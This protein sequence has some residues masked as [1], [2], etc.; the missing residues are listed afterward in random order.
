VRQRNERCVCQHA[1]RAETAHPTS[2]RVWYGR[3]GRRAVVRLGVAWRS[4]ATRR[5]GLGCLRWRAR[6]LACVRVGLCTRSARKAASHPGGRAHMGWTG[7]A[8]GFDLSGVCVR[9]C[10]DVCGVATAATRNRWRVHGDDTETRARQADLGEAVFR[11]EVAEKVRTWGRWLDEHTCAGALGFAATARRSVGHSHRQVKQGLSPSVACVRVRAERRRRGH[12]GD[13]KLMACTRQGNKERGTARDSPTALVRHIRRRTNSRARE[14][15][16]TGSTRK[17]RASARWWCVR[18]KRRQHNRGDGTTPTTW[19]QQWDKDRWTVSGGVCTTRVCAHTTPGQRKARP[20]LDGACS[21]V[22]VPAANRS[23]VTH[24]EQRNDTT[25]RQGSA[26]GD[27]GSGTCKATGSARWPA[28][29]R[30]RVCAAARCGIAVQGHTASSQGS[31]QPQLEGQVHITEKRVVRLTYALDTTTRWWNEQRGM[32]W[33][34]G[35]SAA[36]SM[37]S[38]ATSS[39][40]SSPGSLVFQRGGEEGAVE[41]RKKTGG[42]A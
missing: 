11:V 16:C 9:I 17:N 1:N 30:R 7:R 37:A 3:H 6:S 23:S 14:C 4:G 10:A 33:S 2:T 34:R 41:Q 5:Q 26:R 18:A 35:S 15:T 42:S 19:A 40:C 12:G 13:T 25:A 31:V 38:I 28:L 27:D 29:R 24:V 21:A 32:A 8:E 20:W 36:R 39:L 22:W